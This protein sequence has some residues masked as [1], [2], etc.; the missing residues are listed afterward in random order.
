M[1]SYTFKKKHQQIRWK[2]CALSTKLT[3]RIDFCIVPDDKQST[4]RAELTGISLKDLRSVPTQWNLPVY[5]SERKRYVE[6][7]IEIVRYL[8]DIGI[9]FEVSC[10][11]A[12]FCNTSRW[13]PSCKT[14]ILCRIVTACIPEIPKEK[15]LG[16]YNHTSSYF[17]NCLTEQNIFH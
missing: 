13:N 15:C 10:Q 6:W 5:K 11:A 14:S 16:W 8:S 2:K 7:F 12:T 4:C 17:P 9:L 1:I 3:L